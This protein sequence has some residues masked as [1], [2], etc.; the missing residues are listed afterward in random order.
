MVGASLAVAPSV[1]WRAGAGVAPRAGAAG[2]TIE[3][4]PRVTWCYLLAA[5]GPWR[6]WG[7]LRKGA[8]LS[9]LTFPPLSFSHLHP[10]SPLSN[11]FSFLA[12]SRISLVSL[13]AHVQFSLVATKKTQSPW[14]H[15]S[16]GLA[17]DS[18]DGQS[19]V[20]VG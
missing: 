15:V 19:R 14:T 9:L 10:C 7:G 11:L 3:T 1:A 4:G 5:G 13:A 8:L 12:T 18:E 6:K 2:A 17:L 20:Y 16:T